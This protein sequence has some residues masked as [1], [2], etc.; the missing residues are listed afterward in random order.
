MFGSVVT[1]R[2]SCL[3]SA[4][5]ALVLLTGCAET[6]DD[7]QTPSWSGG[8]ETSTP[9][10]Q[11]E[12]VDGLGPADA[13]AGNRTP[14]SPPATTSS[15]PPSQPGQPGQSSAPPTSARPTPPTRSPS[16]PWTMTVDNTTAGRFSASGNWSRS[17]NSTQR[18]GA[19]YR[20][21]N[22]VE[23]SDVAWYKVAIPQT[24]TYRVEAW[25]PA[26]SSFNDRTPYIVV[27][28]GGN[29]T[30]HVN[31]QANG[32]RWV[33]LGTFTLTAGDENK[34][35]VSRW[36]TAGT[37]YVVADAIRVTRV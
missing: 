18:H 20:Y 37:G 19:D 2:R 14:N 15:T 16:G 13:T 10:L 3:L 33:S 23:S 24:A 29:R 7:G 36:R 31:Q 9:D 12:P 27:T 25:F 4:L 32:G 17:T 6:I 34:V 1:R 5:T 11:P 21:A 22:P 8:T 35:G 30:I 26:K 28:S